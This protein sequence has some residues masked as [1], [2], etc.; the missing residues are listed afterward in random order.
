[1]SRISWGKPRLFVKDT[2]AGSSA[3]WQE[4]YTPVEDSTQLTVKK[5][6]KMEARIEGGEAEDVKY[7]R[8][9]YAVAFNIRKGKIPGGSAIRKL[10]FHSI[11]GY[12]EKHFA[13]LLQP[14]DPTCE[15]FYIGDATVSIDDTYTAAEGGMWQV[16][17]DALKASVGDTVKWGV[18]TVTPGS[19]NQGTLAFEEGS[20]YDSGTTGEGAKTTFTGE[21]VKFVDSTAVNS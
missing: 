14:E 10:P 6:D 13:L 3:T 15:G 8:S 18:V 20:S 19:N 17:M 4:L 7:K 5:G 9:T 11:D 2:D 12:V 21:T 1:M 16:T